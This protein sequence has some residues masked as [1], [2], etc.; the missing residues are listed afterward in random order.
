MPFLKLSGQPSIHYT[1]D[2]F[3]DPW[4]KRPVLILQHGNGRSGRFFYRWIPYLARHYRIVRPDMRGLGQSG[5]DFDLGKAPD[6]WNIIEQP[7]Q[8]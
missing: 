7:Y 5:K 3:T 6:G 2:D 1:V 4:T 8:E